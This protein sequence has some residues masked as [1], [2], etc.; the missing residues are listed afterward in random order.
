MCELFIEKQKLGKREKRRASEKECQGRHIESEAEREKEK[1]RKNK[2]GGG[3]RE[4][5][6]GT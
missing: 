6:R 2:G 1:K 5:G 4:G 3:D